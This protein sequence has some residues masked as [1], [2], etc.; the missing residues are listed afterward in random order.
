MRKI[1]LTGAD[2][3]GKSTVLEVV[4]HQF[5]GQVI[6][7]PEAATMLLSGGFPIPGKD[8]A[9]SPEWQVAFQSAVLPVQIQ[10]EAAYE[11]K[12]VEQGAWI[13]VCDRGRLDGAG[14]TPGGLEEFCRLYG[15]NAEEALACYVAV[16]H[17]ES[18]AVGDSESYER[19]RNA[20]NS[21][22]FRTR[23]DAAN[24]D[25]A[26]RAAWQKHPSWT[27]VSCVGGL[28]GKI[29]AVCQSLR[30]LITEGR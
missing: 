28:E 30:W 12:A 7:V 16:Y 8:L 18:T 13:L 5:A 27:L 25:H 4:R 9:W 21:M 14:F 1:V 20:N 26:I 3:G 2:R 24:L 19:D 10:M 17:L 11:L 23:E 15:V 22:R 6:V 29:Q